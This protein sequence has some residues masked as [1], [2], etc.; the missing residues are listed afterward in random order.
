MS[1]GDIRE[2]W[3]FASITVNKTFGKPLKSELN[4]IIANQVN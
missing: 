3:E 4:V 2:F 1:G